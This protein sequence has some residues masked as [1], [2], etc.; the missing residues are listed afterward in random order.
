MKFWEAPLP[1]STP[2]DT[3]PNATYSYSNLWVEGDKT[4]EVETWGKN[5]KKFCL[6]F[7][8]TVVP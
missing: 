4:P 6:H 5:A 3:V 2:L 8:T 7:H 1:S